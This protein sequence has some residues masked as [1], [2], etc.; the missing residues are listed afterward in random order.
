MTLLTI[1]LIVLATLVGAALYLAARA[2]PAPER[3]GTRRAVVI[4][5]DPAGHLIVSDL[6]DSLVLRATRGA[7]LGATRVGDVVDVI[8][9]YAGHAIALTVAAEAQPA[10]DL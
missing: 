8:E 7:G 4:A 9:P 10:G 5:K 6:T 3:T 2:E 1:T